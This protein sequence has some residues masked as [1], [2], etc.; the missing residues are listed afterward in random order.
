MDFRY[1]MSTTSVL[2]KP[3]KGPE[4]IFDWCQIL[5]GWDMPDFDVQHVVECNEGEILA[6]FQ[7]TNTVKATGKS[8]GTYDCIFRCSV[9]NGK[10]AHA[11]MHQGPGAVALDEA[12][13]PDANKF[14]IVEHEFRSPEKA[15]E[16]WKNTAEL[17]SDA[18]KVNA[19]NKKQFELGFV[20][21]QFLP[22][23]A[24]TDKKMQCLWECKNTVT[25]EE[26]QQ[27]IDGPYG[28]DATDCIINHVSPENLFSPGVH[29]PGWEPYGEETKDPDRAAASPW[30]DMLNADG[31]GPGSSAA[32]EERRSRLVGSST[33]RS[34]PA[35]APEAGS[36]EA[37]WQKARGGAEGS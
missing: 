7:F 8:V 26:F 9:V 21:H 20:F 31:V 37:A 19:S 11:M 10:I 30:A 13:T 15:E 17:F 16:W 5:A 25:K 35:L 27:F 32:W 14:F 24:G 2:D 18:E 23:A 22:Q 34:T 28:P 36:L 3:F 4:G 33:P 6:L 1:P 29:G 12:H